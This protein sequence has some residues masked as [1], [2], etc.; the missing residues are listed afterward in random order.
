MRPRAETNHCPVLGIAALSR[1]VLGSLYL[2]GTGPVSLYIACIPYIPCIPVYTGACIYVY[3]RVLAYIPVYTVYR[4]VSRDIGCIPVYSLYTR[5][6]GYV[7]GLYIACIHVYTGSVH[8]I[9]LIQGVS[10]DIG[11][12]PYIPVY[13]LNTGYVQGLYIGELAYIPVYTVYPGI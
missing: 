1:A 10:R 13:R 9:P 3:T 7:Q 4:P 6:T 8:G 2:T 5:Y 12:I 11:C